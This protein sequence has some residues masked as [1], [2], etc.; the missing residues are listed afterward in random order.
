MRNGCPGSRSDCATAPSSTAEPSRD[1]SK[2]AMNN[3]SP[4]LFS[5]DCILVSI[6][7]HAID[8]YMPFVSGFLPHPALFRHALGGLVFGGAKAFPLWLPSSC[9]QEIASL[10]DRTS[11]AACRSDHDHELCLRFG[12]SGLF[13]GAID[14]I[15]A[16]FHGSNPLN[17]SSRFDYHLYSGSQNLCLAGLFPKPPTCRRYPGM[18]RWDS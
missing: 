10:H 11:I 8:Q 5:E 3:T 17:I 1:P 6:P 13:R 7:P 4:T 12:E 16:C 15:V 18:S 9:C 2:S 14:I